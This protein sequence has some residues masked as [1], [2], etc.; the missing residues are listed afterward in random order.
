MNIFKTVL[1]ALSAIIISGTADAQLY[2]SGSFNF[3]INVDE[4]DYGSNITSD[5]IRYF[6]IAPDVG[7]YFRDNMA[8]GV[9]VE[10]GAGKVI[11]TSD[12]REGTSMSITLA[13]YF[14]YDF[15]GND[16]LALGIMASPFLDFSNSKSDGVATNKYTSFGVRLTPVLNYKFNGHWSAMCRFG[17]AYYSHF[18]RKNV[19][20]SNSDFVSN[21]FMANL[22]LSSLYFGFMYTF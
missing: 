16:K 12:D 13:P 19:G 10:F 8:V 9:S 1:A 17:S 21:I 18:K 4:D 2:V 3:K 15:V 14:R 20:G 22:D 7:Y 11:D 5:K 6:S